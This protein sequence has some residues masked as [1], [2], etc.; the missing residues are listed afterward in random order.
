MLVI[1]LIM[2]RIVSYFD[3]DLDKVF[4][5]MIFFF[6]LIRFLRKWIIFILGVKL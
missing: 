4:I 3:V 5:F 2:M 6:N 1:V